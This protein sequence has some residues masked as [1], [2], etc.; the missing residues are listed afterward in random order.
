MDPKPTLQDIKMLNSDLF[1]GLPDHQLE[2][3]CSIMQTVRME[4]G[5]MVIKEGSVS[6]EVYI[7]WKGEVD[8]IKKEKE[9]GELFYLTTCKE[10]ESIGEMSLLD[11][12]PRSASVIVSKDSMLLKIGMQDL[13]NIASENDSAASRIK[14][15]FAKE[16]GQRLR[17]STETTVTTLYDKLEEAHDRV[18][19]GTV[20]CW[21]LVGICSYV[22]A[23]QSIS[24]LSDKVASTTL[25]SGS[26][27]IVLGIITVLGIVR[28]GYPIAFFGLTLKNWPRVTVQ[29]I[30]YSFPLLAVIALA[31]WALILFHPKMADSNLLDWSQ[32]LNIS[33]MALA[34]DILIYAMF[35][36]VQEFIA[37]GGVQSPF[38]SFLTDKYKNLYAIL[39]ANLMFSMTHIHLST[40]FAMLVFIPGLFW[41]WLYYKQRTLV[42]VCVSHILIGLIAY[43]VIGFQNLL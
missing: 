5:D 21:I 25:I 9:S 40:V 33:R 29:A 2:E 20:I 1:K 42:G 31:K 26:V 23:L 32:N 36:P 30:I 17:R 11:N 24:A 13:N 16:V 15:N 22:F 28:S 19:M 14:V 3:V 12:E 6:D 39:I 10:G 8:V 27:L 35:T 4:K 18:A 43:Y 7:I 37:R 38:Q 41:G 34:G